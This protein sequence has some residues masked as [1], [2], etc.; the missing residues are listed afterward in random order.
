MDLDIL[1]FLK[2]RYFADVKIRIQVYKS[3]NG[4]V[5]SGR[6]R[7]IIEINLHSIRNTVV[8]DGGIVVVVIARLCLLCTKL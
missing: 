8:A 2:H 5:D 4:V 6:M 1:E 7:N 3:F